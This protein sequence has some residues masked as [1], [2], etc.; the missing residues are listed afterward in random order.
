MQDENIKEKLIPPFQEDTSPSPYVG[1][2]KFNT[3]LNS[4][5]F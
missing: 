3:K 1:Y 2:Q 4:D 5:D